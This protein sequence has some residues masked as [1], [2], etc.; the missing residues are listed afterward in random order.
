MVDDVDPVGIIN[1]LQQA[2]STLPDAFALGQSLACRIDRVYLVAHG[3]ANRA[4]LGLAYWIEHVS[5]TLEVRRYFPSEF[6]AQNPAKLDA[7]TLVLIASKSGTTPETIGAAEFLR[8]KP[9]PTIA[10]TLTGERQLARLAQTA[11]L[12]GDTS[13][14]FVA[15]FMLMQA[16][17]GGILTGRREW[18]LGERLLT[19]LSRLPEAVADAA[20]ANDR[21]AAE[22]AHRYK[23][24]T[25]LYQV[26]S[27]PGFTT[28]YVFGVCI[29]MEMLWLHS[30][31]IEAAEFFHGPFEIVDRNTPL[32]LILG[33]DP[34][35]P[36]MERVVRFCR[37]HTERLMIYDSR[38][39]AMPGI[40]PAIRP[41]VAPYVLQ[42]ALKRLSSRLSVWHGK[43]LGT[44]RYMWQTEY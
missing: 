7:R 20:V 38:D 1:S 37:K 32:M 9:C 4:M 22:E 41:I 24:D 42:A 17:V 26:A 39:F 40:D 31:P 30:Y 16:V 5:P 29:L 13:E 3:S 11:L 8:D 18:A 34:S 27:G 14:S 25:I 12:P 6:V 28:A 19:S 10:F 2:V 21:R 23:H 15:L 35:R 43:P 33:E 44:R 36:L